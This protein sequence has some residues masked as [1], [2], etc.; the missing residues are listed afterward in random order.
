LNNTHPHSVTGNIALVNYGIQTEQSDLRAHVCPNAKQVY[1][2]PTLKGVEAINTNRYRKITASQQGANFVTAE[3]Y[4]VPPSKIWGCISINAG[5]AMKK[6]GPV[7][8]GMSTTAKG[9]WAVQVVQQLLKVGWFPLF[10]SP[11]IVEN[12]EIQVKGIDVIVTSKVRI[13][14]KCDFDGGEPTSEG[15]VGKRVTGNLFLQTAECNPFRHK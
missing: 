3:G 7:D 1:V 14:V 4:L 6:V 2:Y 13:Q 10:G 5:W 11:E 12:T 15:P 9:E 8:Y